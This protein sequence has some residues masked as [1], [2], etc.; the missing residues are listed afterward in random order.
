MTAEDRFVKAVCFIA[1]WL[2]ADKAD[3]PLAHLKKAV[4]AFA[5]EQDFLHA[6]E[7]RTRLLARVFGEKP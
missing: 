3:K 1:G 7:N 2:A 5:D 6:D 4:E